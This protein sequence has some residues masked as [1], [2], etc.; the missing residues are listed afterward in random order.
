MTDI[1]PLDPQAQPPADPEND[2]LLNAIK[3][4]AIAGAG[5]SDNAEQMHRFAQ[6]AEGFA[7]ALLI[8]HTPPPAPAP[9][10]GQSGPSA[11]SRTDG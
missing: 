6:A 8:L 11:E 7:N 9:P 5:A 1:S 10:P 4:A 2:A 3:Q